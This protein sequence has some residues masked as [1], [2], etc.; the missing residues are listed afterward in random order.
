MSVDPDHVFLLARRALSR[1]ANMMLQTLT[2]GDMTDEEVAAL[3]AL[4]RPIHRRSTADPVPPAPVLELVPSAR[5][6]KR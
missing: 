2:W 3:A 5:K 4:L 1:E 6:R